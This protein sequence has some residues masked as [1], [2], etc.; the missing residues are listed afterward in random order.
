M[1]RETVALPQPAHL[2]G[3][4]AELLGRF[5]VLELQFEDA[6]EDAFAQ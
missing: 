4:E 3:R 6:A 5:D 1:L 2:A